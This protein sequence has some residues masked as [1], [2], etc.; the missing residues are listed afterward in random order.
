MGELSS[1]FTL[2]VF[3]NPSSE[4]CKKSLQA[5]FEVIAEDELIMFI[6][7]LIKMKSKETDCTCYAE[8]YLGG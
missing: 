1:C 4:K 3:I 8:K 2:T 5:W 7:N 6:E